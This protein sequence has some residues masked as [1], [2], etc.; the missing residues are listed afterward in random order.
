MVKETRKKGFE[1]TEF[2]IDNDNINEF[3][4]LENRRQVSN[5]HVATIHNAILSGKNPIG[6]LIVNIR[7]GK[8]RLIDGNHRIE[9]IKRFYNYK[10]SYKDTKIECVLKV[11]NN[12][13][14]EE[15]RE[16]YSNE[17]KRKNESYEDRLNMYKSTIT[18]WKLLTDSTN[19][20]PCNINIYPSKEGLR[21]RLMLMAFAAMKGNREGGTYT[22][23]YL[24]KEN[25]VEFA[26]GLGYDDYLLFKEFIEFFVT[27]FG[28]IG[29]ENFYMCNQFF[30]P[31]FDIYCKN[32]QYINDPNFAERF[33]RVVGR[34]DIMSYYQM[35]GRETQIKVRQLLIEHMNYRVS[36]HLFT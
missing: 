8:M 19:K 35:G 4:L 13:T 1:I 2:T 20:F 5:T 18:L 28:K 12:L 11:Y 36:K 10:E 32:R 23:V 21:F 27:V 25:I 22:P 31:I 15:E 16:V 34:T 14:D 6:V 26:K 24:P 17:A 3:E 9:S 30:I 33:I 29:K 7:S